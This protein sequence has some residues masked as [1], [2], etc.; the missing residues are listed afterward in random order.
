[1]SPESSETPPETLDEEACAW[2]A[3]LE[4]DDVSA[5]EQAEFARWLKRSPDHARAWSELLALM[6]ALEAPAKHIRAAAAPAR[7]PPVLKP[8][9]RRRPPKP[10]Q[11]AAALAFAAILGTFWQPDLMQDLRS[12][13]H[14]AKGEQQRIELA[15]GSRLLLNTDTALTVHLSGAERRVRL[16]RGEAFFEVAHAPLRPFRVE[17][18][19]ARARVTGTAF[20]VSRSRDDVVIRVAEGRVE[21]SSVTGDTESVPLAPGDSAHYRDARL[22]ERTAADLGRDLAWRQGKLVFV[23]TPLAE[24]AAEINRYRP[25]RLVIVDPALANRPVTA[26]FAIGR[27]DDAVEA[28]EKTFGVKAR[29]FGSYFV[30][31]G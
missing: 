4:A 23:Q 15:D 31:L 10:V 30:F 2:F 29:S 24:V 16:L 22:M 7:L 21:T 13:F 26:V 11:A 6:A 28:L 1:M 9:R 25:G 14:T 5:K 19:S 8:R 18:G 20:S 17:A 12:D 3:R 27:L